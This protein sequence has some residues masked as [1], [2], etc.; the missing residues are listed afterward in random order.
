MP[1][2]FG[3]RWYRVK[4]LQNTRAAIASPVGEASPRREER[5][6]MKT[7]NL[8]I[9]TLALAA[10]TCAFAQDENSQPGPGGPNGGHRPP[11]PLVATLDANHD[12]VIDATEIDQASASL[13]KLD[14][15]G[16]GKLTMDELRPPMGPGPQGNGPRGNRPPFGD[17]QEP[18]Q[19]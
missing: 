17:D 16:D 9:A 15:N 7:R 4:Y 8:I 12:G 2:H 6:D 13:R 11:P 19:N 5:I 1:L 18:L 14:K 10:A 3:L